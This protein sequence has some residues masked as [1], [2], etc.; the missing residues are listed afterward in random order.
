[1]IRALAAFVV[2]AGHLGQLIDGQVGQ[3]VAV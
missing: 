1:M 2:D 3:V